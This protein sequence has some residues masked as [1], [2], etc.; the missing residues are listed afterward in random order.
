[1][2]LFSGLVDYGGIR[3]FCS[4]GLNYHRNPEDTNPNE[5][6]WESAGKM[7]SGEG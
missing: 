7:L 4:L 2:V 6:H 3:R 5:D 1:M